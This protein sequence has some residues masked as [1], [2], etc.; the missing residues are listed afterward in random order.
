[1][2]PEPTSPDTLARHLL[3]RARQAVEIH[4]IALDECDREIHEWQQAGRMDK[5]D[6]IFDLTRPRA[7]ATLKDGEAR[8]AD[9]EREIEAGWRP[10][11]PDSPE[12]LDHA[13]ALT[14]LNRRTAEERGQGHAYWREREA[15]V[16][17]KAA[18]ARRRHVGQAAGMGRPVAGIRARRP[19]GRP[20]ARRSSS[21]SRA[22]PD[23]GSGLDEPP[24]DL[25]GREGD[26]QEE[27]RP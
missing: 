23:D 20:G 24:G 9:L 4:R 6:Q 26:S 22:G 21:P 19:S 12:V 17:T 15:E 2:T 1:M 18:L 13:A 27:G 5:A 10:P 11:A 7:V 16:R 8:L 14:S 3:D 25:A